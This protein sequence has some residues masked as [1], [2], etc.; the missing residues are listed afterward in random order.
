MNNETIIGERIYSERKK[1]SYTQKQVAD[2]IG[3]SRSNYSNIEKNYNKPSVDVLNKLSEFFGCSTDY[4][5]GKTDKRTIYE[6]FDEQFP[7]NKQEIKN[8]EEISKHLTD[9]Q[10]EELG[11]YSFTDNNKIIPVAMFLGGLYDMGLLKEN[12]PITEKQIKVILDFIEKNKDYIK[13]L[14]GK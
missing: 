8:L 12:E 9:K 4:L 6:E 2:R 14:M 1:L 3:I 5:L 11:F 7:I 10:K 13:F